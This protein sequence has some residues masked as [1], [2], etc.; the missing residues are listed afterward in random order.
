[1]KY[2]MTVLFAL[3]AAWT[4]S[5]HA[6]GRSPASLPRP[7]SQGEQMLGS[8]RDPSPAFAQPARRATGPL[9]LLGACGAPGGARYNSLEKGY[10]ACIENSGSGSVGAA[11]ASRHVGA[12]VDLSR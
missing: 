8:L 6:G 5:A 10:S 4:H 3:F 1:M 7:A 12:A 11:S 2:L 9:Q